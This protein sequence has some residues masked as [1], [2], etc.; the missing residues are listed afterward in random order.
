MISRVVLNSN[1]I[2][3]GFLFGGPPARLIEHIV[4]GTLHCFTSLPILDEVQ[5]V[6]QRPKFGL[7]PEQAFL[8]VEE[9]YYSCTLVK[10]G[11]RI[12]AISADPDD[13]MILECASEANAD[14]I[15]SGDLH[16]LDLGSW[17]HIQILSPANA[18][19]KIENQR[20]IKG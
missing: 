20:K 3:S 14:L 7:S 13:D 8:L 12:R 15:I 10:P 5:E 4:N 18:L 17:E 2:I 11:R 1:V 19:K 9:L 16:L 6:L